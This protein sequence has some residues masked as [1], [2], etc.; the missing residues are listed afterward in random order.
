MDALSLAMICSRLK[1]QAEAVQRWPQV[2]SQ[3]FAKQNPY[4]SAAANPSQVGK[5]NPIVS[6]QSD[7]GNLSMVAMLA[8][9][10]CVRRTT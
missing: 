1:P 3:D 8:R 9:F 10:R 6:E 7:T 5:V 2:V 4:S